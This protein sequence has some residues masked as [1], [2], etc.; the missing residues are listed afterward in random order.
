[1]VLSG[2][3]LVSSED[4]PVDKYGVAVVHVALEGVDR[5]QVYRKD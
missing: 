4:S 5:E 2:E 1:M 3:F